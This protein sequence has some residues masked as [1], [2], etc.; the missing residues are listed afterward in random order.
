MQLK[1]FTAGMTYLPLNRV[2]ID[3]VIDRLTFSFVVPT[4]TSDQWIEHADGAGERVEVRC[5]SPNI[6]GMIGVPRHFARQHYSH[7]ITQ[8]FT[9][10]PRLEPNAWGT[11]I[12]P[13]DAAQRELWSKLLDI[14]GEDGPIDITVNATT[15]AGKTVTAMALSA[16]LN[17]RAC[18]IVP[19][20]RLKD[21]WIGDSDKRNGLLHFFGIDWVAANVGVVQQDRCEFDGIVSIAMAPSLALRVYPAAFYRRFGIVWYDEVHQ[22][23]SPDRKRVLDLFHARIR[24]GLTATNREDALIKVAQAN[25]GAPRVKSKQKVLKPTVY[26]RAYHKVIR[27]ALF[28]NEHVLL[29]QV[30]FDDERNTRLAN[31]IAHRIKAGRK[32]LGLSDRIAQLQDICKRLQNDHGIAASRIGVY[33][34]QLPTGLWRGTVTFEDGKRKNLATGASSERQ[35]TDALDR[36]ATVNYLVHGPEV[37]RNVFEEKRKLTETELDHMSKNCDCLLASYGIF[38]TGLDNDMLDC[39]VECS[40]RGDVKQA[41]GRVLRIKTGKLA[42]EWYSIADTWVDVNGVVVQH[43]VDLSYARQQ[44]FVFH[45][46]DIRV[47]A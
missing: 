44:S 19:T 6:D 10:F 17:T 8:D 16:A 2:D 20:N 34:A 31:L 14:F 27:S 32:V 21:Q 43:L 18:F 15:G 5:Y 41:L 33:V 12:E 24:V 28:Y 30:V 25:F 4:G 11:K 26:V 29:N 47:I 39:G 45:G 7:L 42:P 38:S 9:T 23:F 1:P 35:A 37:K 36:L 13:R 22:Y 3:Q 40:P 46:A